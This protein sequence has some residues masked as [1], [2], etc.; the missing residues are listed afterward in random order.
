MP[1]PTTTPTPAPTETPAPP[2]IPAVTRAEAEDW[3]STQGMV[4]LDLGAPDASCE[5]PITPSKW[6]CSVAIRYYDG[7]VAE[8]CPVEMI[9][10]RSGEQTEPAYMAY[11]TES[12]PPSVRQTPHGSAVNIDEAKVCHETLWVIF[13][14]FTFSK[15]PT[16][17]VSTPLS[18]TE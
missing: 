1:T 18:S 12:R 5:E 7:D 8:E 10:W 6:R 2:E 17:H 16:R 9:V 11:D 13:V 15:P 14:R 3:A 4:D